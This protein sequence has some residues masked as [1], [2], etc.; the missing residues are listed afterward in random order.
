[1]KLDG[2]MT[3]DGTY[4][5]GRYYET[6]LNFMAQRMKLDGVSSSV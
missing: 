3:L 6:G 1:M 4:D 5:T 2:T